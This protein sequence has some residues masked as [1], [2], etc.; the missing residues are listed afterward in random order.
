MTQPECVVLIGLQAAGKTTFYRQRFAATHEHVSKDN[1]RHARDRDARQNRL[2]EDALSAGR[3]VV[4]D[5]TNATPSER[6]GAIA[7][8]HAL[9]AR[10]VAYFFEPSTRS[11]LG[12]NRGREGKERVPDVAIFATAKRLVP[13]TLEE[14]FDQ[15]FVVRVTDQGEFQ[16]APAPA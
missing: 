9:G 4:V 1:F 2:I 14:G 16:V 8:A 11:S 7:L 12:R 10:A 15:M 13:P 3:S 5:N 6:R